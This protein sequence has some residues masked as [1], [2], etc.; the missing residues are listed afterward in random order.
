MLALSWSTG[1]T[2]RFLRGL[3]G[4]ALEGIGD[5]VGVFP[6]AIGVALDID[7]NGMVQQA[8]KQGGGHD[9]VAEDGSPVP[10]AAIGGKDG[11]ALLVTGIDELEEQVGAAG[12][13]GQVADL[14]DDKQ[15]DPV[16]IAQARGEG[17]GAFGLGQG[18]D[19]FGQGGYESGAA[20]DTAR[21]S[22]A[23]PAPARG[24]RYGCARWS[25]RRE[26]SWPPGSR[27]PGNGCCPQRF[28]AVRWD[29]RSAVASPGRGVG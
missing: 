5:Q 2:F 21:R 28:P 14:I 24:G 11:S 23:V 25:R 3:C 9:V 16:N 6:Q 20:R 7:D 18:G 26:S 29:D 17:A 15:G 19:E 4:L 13:D 1:F 22:C 8:V 12:F 10:A 27:R